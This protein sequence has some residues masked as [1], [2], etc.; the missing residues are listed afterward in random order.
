MEGELR[1]STLVQS[2]GRPPLAGC[3][4]HA[5]HFHLAAARAVDAPHGVHEKGLPGSESSSVPSLS[6]L[7]TRMMPPMLPPWLRS[8]AERRALPILPESECDS[9][10][11]LSPARQTQRSESTTGLS[12]MV[13][14][15]SEL[16]P[17][18]STREARQRFAGIARAAGLGVEMRCGTHR[19]R[20]AGWSWA[21]LGVGTIQGGSRAI[22][23]SL[24][25]A[26]ISNCFIV[27]RT[28][29]TLS[30]RRIEIARFEVPT[31]T[32]CSSTTMAE[33]TPSLC[34]AMVAAPHRERYPPDEGCRPHRAPD[35]LWFVLR[36]RRSATS[37]TAP[38][39]FSVASRFP[40]RHFQHPPCPAEDLPRLCP[41][42]SDG[43]TQRLSP[44]DSGEG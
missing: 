27:R 20:R 31:G 35:F 14:Q 38:S 22:T 5:P 26:L 3:R 11:S 10:H 37:R 30:R 19:V 21:A 15:V 28:L 23:A 34:T 16:A 33:A 9:Q 43:I 32:C 13:G 41:S 36:S 39:R 24:A 25:P 1:H 42:K 29:R 44:A 4:R 40:H 7:G 18:N 12:R 2:L 8:A 6:L 17:W